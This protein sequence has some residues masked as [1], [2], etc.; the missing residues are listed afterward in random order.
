MTVTSS[1]SSCYNSRYDFNI[2]GRRGKNYTSHIC[3]STNFCFWVI[4]TF[5]IPKENWEVL[6]GKGGQAEWQGQPDNSIYHTLVKIECGKS[7]CN[8]HP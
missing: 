3:S 7:V 4:Q 2:K 6:S 8:F 5:L 1:Q